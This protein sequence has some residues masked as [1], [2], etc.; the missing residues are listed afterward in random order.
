MRKVVP[1]QIL[2]IV[3]QINSGMIKNS[4]STAVAIFIYSK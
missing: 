2:P 4:P 3:L 1:L